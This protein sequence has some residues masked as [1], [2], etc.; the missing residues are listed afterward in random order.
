LAEA[1][2]ARGKG[3]FARALAAAR[4]AANGGAEPAA[5]GPAMEARLQEGAIL[6]DMG[7]LEQAARAL[8]QALERYEASG[9][10][11][12]Q[13]RTLMERARLQRLAGNLE[14]AKRIELKLLSAFG[15]L[16]QR[17]DVLL[18]HNELGQL[19]H[20]EGQLAA[21]QRH[22]EQALSLAGAIHDPLLAA[23][24]ER[25]LASVLSDRGELQ[26]ARTLMARAL[27]TLRRAESRSEATLGW[28]TLAQIQARQ[29]DLGGARAAM[30]SGWESAAPLGHWVGR[31]SATLVDAQLSLEEN[32]PE[33]AERAG[34]RAAE[35]A[36]RQRMHGIASKAL[37]IVARANL[38]K[39][40]LPEAERALHGA[41][42][43]AA[44]GEDRIALLVVELAN[45]GLQRASGKPEEALAEAERV[46]REAEQL[47]LRPLAFEARLARAEIRAARTA[48]PM[49]DDR[50]EIAA[51]EHDARAA[52]FVGIAD[53][54]ARLTA[55]SPPAPPAPP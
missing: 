25:H 43:A 45:V 37:A 22:H 55:G 23:V 24:S 54:A 34:A 27:T 46:R 1:R 20:A 19:L 26:A 17:S 38:E 15:K 48:H 30:E 14:Q 6:A 9:D 3:D 28:I 53:R 40:K 49:A 31:T 5:K 50:P 18:V 47:G 10:L 44:H 16:A 39:G 7:A 2:E 13:A 36:E 11:L 8:E 52:G 41:L 35:E 29:G 51:L 4:E 12:G 21:A 32:H 42:E 33:E